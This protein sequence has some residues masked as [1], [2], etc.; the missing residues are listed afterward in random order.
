[1]SSPHDS[2]HGGPFYSSGAGFVPRFEPPR[3][4]RIYYDDGAHLPHRPHPPHPA[5]TSASARPTSHTTS[6]EELAARKRSI[7]DSIQA[8]ADAAVAE[9]EVSRIQRRQYGR[10]SR[11]EGVHD[12]YMKREEDEEKEEDIEELCDVLL[13]EYGVEVEPLPPGARAPIYGPTVR[14]A[15]PVTE[16]GV[17]RERERRSRMGSE[18]R[19]ELESSED[20]EEDNEELVNRMSRGSADRLKAQTSFRGTYHGYERPSG[21]DWRRRRDPYDDSSYEAPSRPR[22]KPR[23][24]G[25][26]PTGAEAPFPMEEDET[27]ER[28][29]EWEREQEMRRGREK[30]KEREIRIE[31]DIRRDELEREIR[32]DELE[33]E[34]RR[35][36]ERSRCQKAEN[37]EEWED[38][39]E[40]TFVT[41]R[42]PPYP[43]VDPEYGFIHRPRSEYDLRRT[44]SYGGPSTAANPAYE[45][46]YRSRGEIRIQR[47]SEYPSSGPRPRSR[48]PPGH[49]DMYMHGGRHEKDAPAPAPEEGESQDDGVRRRRRSRKR[50]SYREESLRMMASG[51]GGGAGRGETY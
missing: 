41:S 21:G 36:E 48:S 25:P 7:L 29:R 22:P 45:A 35:N 19:P 13:E 40:Q 30:R 49:L 11:P 27:R 15:W 14:A 44:E 47:R 31:R 8:E 3:G 23:G 37:E 38:I 1:M 10:S 18:S 26:G 33:R 28:K 43:H 2:D 50:E 4:E 42:R 16:E 24:P 20:S 6:R 9:L 51:G 46:G 5:A 39:H 12:N 34:M 17:G 32:R